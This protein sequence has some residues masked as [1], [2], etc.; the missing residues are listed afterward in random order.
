MLNAIRPLLDS[1]I[2]NED[3]RQAISE[4]WE[5]QLA[6]AKETVRSE[7]REEFSQRYE[8]DKGVMVKALDSMVTESLSSEIQDF[9]AD[10]QALAED[11]VKYKH[12]VRESGEKFNKFLISKLSE[13]MKELRADRK[14]LKEASTTLEQFVVGALAEEIGEFAKDK[15]DVVE[16]KVRLVAEGKKK[17]AEM[18]KRFITRSAKLV[19]ESVTKNLNSEL[20]NLKEDIQVAR[21]NMFGRRLFE[22]FASEFTLT[23][24]NENQEIRKLR[25]ALN[26]KDRQLAETV[27]KT[28]NANKIVESKEKEIRIIKESAERNSK[29]VELLKPRNKE[30]AAV[31]SSLLESVQTGK[32]QS[33]YDKYLPA[34]LNNSISKQSEKT[35]L[36]ESRT[37][38]TGDKGAKPLQV[39]AENTDMNNVVELK[40]LAGLK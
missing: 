3:T 28:I 8:H 29:M 30:K 6:E 2:I 16:T 9:V 26:V 38:V 19:Q 37:A 20:S 5:A 39:E 24:L 33:A 35:T 4:A 34:V 40:R 1:G 10:K 21:E 13:E 32:L 36:N 12:F 18:Q 7:L 15:R 27:K 14:S 31:M 22:A 23:H 11:R 25:A 17:L